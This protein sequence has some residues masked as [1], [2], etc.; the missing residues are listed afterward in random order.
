VFVNC[1][2]GLWVLNGADVQIYQNTFVN[3]TV[4]IGRDGRSAVGDHFGWHP[5]TGPDV[6]ERDGH[7]FVNNLLYGNEA[8]K[9]PLLFV[10][11]NPA[12][13]ERVK[14]QQFKQ[15]DYNAFI[16]NR[17][18]NVIPM[19]LWGPSSSQNCQVSFDSPA[20]IH[21]SF[22]EFSAHCQSE[23]KNNMQLFRS[24]DLG[25]YQLI[26]SIQGAA[27]LPVEIKELL[28]I[29]KKVPPYIGAYRLSE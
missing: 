28:G 26:K 16:D 1:D 29:G 10:W 5:S 21:S 6:E 24:I 22:P 18:E 8:Y 11:Q 25:N 14:N 13:C 15:L 23:I 27:E 2:H 9:H 3:S 4:C 7:V 20:N 17:G 12:I 19:I